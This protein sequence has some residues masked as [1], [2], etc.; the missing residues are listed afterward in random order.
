MQEKAYTVGIYARL[1]VDSHNQKNDSIETQLQA[2][3][4]YLGKQ[5]EMTLYDCYCDLGKTGTDFDRPAFR[6]LLQDIY[7]QRVNCVIV[8]DFSRLGRDYIETGNYIQRVFPKL[9]T[10][11]VS[12]TDNF[13]SLFGENDELGLHLKNLSNEMYAKDISI[14]VKTAKRV[15]KESGSYTGGTPPYGCQIRR[16]GEKRALVWDEGAVEVVKNIYRLLDEGK[17]PREVSEWL[18]REEIHRP[19]EYRRLGHVRREGEEELYQWSRET[20]RAVRKN[21]VYTESGRIPRAHRECGQ[22]GTGGKQIAGEKPIAGEKLIA[23]RRTTAARRKAESDIF[24]GVLYCGECK[25]KM[26]KSGA[27]YFCRNAS[28][29]DARRCEKKYIS[30]KELEEI[31]YAF[32]KSQFTLDHAE[33]DVILQKCRSCGEQGQR[34]ALKRQKQLLKRLDW[35]QREEN[36]CYQEYR[37]G[38]LQKEAFLM[39]KEERERQKGLLRI[40]LEQERE[41]E[42]ELKQKIMAREQFLQELF[43]GERTAAFHRDFTEALQMKIYVYPEKRVEILCR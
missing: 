1:S 36:R 25:K 42:R 24:S 9:G 7:L 19:T 31:F 15:R 34:D 29:I 43:A 18:Y 5:Q 28:R 14:K 4:A 8:K 2:A 3:K 41:K 37:A 22:Q 6:R 23:G 13:D 21:P 10:R 32:V 35:E 11:F 30:Q 33:Q 17:N 26:Q 16:L 27:G 20:V 38:A 12:I 39:Q 40:K